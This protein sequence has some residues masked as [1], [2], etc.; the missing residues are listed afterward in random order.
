MAK[1]SFNPRNLAPSPERKLHPSQMARYTRRQS[2]DWEVR[3]QL[4]PSGALNTLPEANLL[5]KHGLGSVQNITLST[6]FSGSP[7]TTGG[8]IL[9][10][11]GLVAGQ[12]VQIVMAG[13]A[14]PG[15]YMR[16][17]T[18]AGTSPVWTPPLP[19]A[20]AA[21]DTLKGVVTYSL[22]T[23]L[24]KSLTIAHYPQAPAAGVPAREM[25]GCVV[26]KL[27]FDFDSNLEPMITASGPAQ[28]FSGTSPNWT[29]Q[30]QPGAF[31]TVGAE[32]AIPSGL[33]GYFYFGGT[34]YQ[35]EKLQIEVD[36][37]MDLQ[38]T[39]LGTNKASAFFRKS[40]RK[41]TVKIDAKVSDD[42]TLWTPS[43]ASTSNALFLQLGTTAARMWSV[44]CPGIV[45]STIPDTPDN[46][47]TTNWSFVGTAD[48]VS[49]A[50]NDEITIAQG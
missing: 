8:T 24:S 22:A 41:N 11:T 6:T 29:P 30:A 28:G 3:G 16:V 13:G 42:T 20:P 38:N 49:S 37:G 43:A 17:L 19:A 32:S 50:G 27:T 48:G 39:A 44:Y 45:L 33:T 23:A 4:Y 9:S 18:T 35:I 36:N 1:L 21:G 15:T 7:S 25:L 10:G 5:L 26:N 12:M 31:T 2:A 40:K 47:E 14:A 34:L 46:D